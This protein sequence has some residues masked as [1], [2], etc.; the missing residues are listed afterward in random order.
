MK[1][2][3]LRNINI[4]KAAISETQ[5]I[6]SVVPLGIPH[7]S[8][9]SVR[10]G[11][12]EIPRKSMIIP[13]QWAVHMNPIDWPD[14]EHF[15]PYRFL[16]KDGSYKAPSQFIPFQTGKRM[17]PGDE[18]GKMILHLYAGHILR[19]FKISLPRFEQISFDGTCGITLTPPA[20]HL[21]FERRE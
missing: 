8:S 3:T 4:L 16:L 12:Y 11:N 21:M 1:Y 5:R 7:G 9:E 15:N 6:R 10:L 2:D 18:L 20:Y 13:L 14:P 17:C 19:A